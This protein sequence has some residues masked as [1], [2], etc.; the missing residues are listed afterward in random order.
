MKRLFDIKGNVIYDKMETLH[1]VDFI[2]V[3]G[4]QEPFTITG[5]QHIFS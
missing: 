1:I 2:E 3:S 4:A 5:T